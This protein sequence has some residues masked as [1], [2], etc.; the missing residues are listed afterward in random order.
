M[1]Q[2]ISAGMFLTWFNKLLPEALT[3]LPRTVRGRTL[4]WFLPGKRR[5]DV[6]FVRLWIVK[7]K[8]NSLRDQQ[9]EKRKCKLQYRVKYLPIYRGF[10]AAD[11]QINTAFSPWQ[12]RGMPKFT[13]VLPRF[14]A[15]CNIGVN[16]KTR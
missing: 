16:G 9:V 5:C 11:S 14:A 12:R 1:F 3:G 2:K 4:Q 15:A 13:E 10:A 8:K 7:S 6:S